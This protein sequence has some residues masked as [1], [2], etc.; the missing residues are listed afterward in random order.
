MTYPSGQYPQYPQ[1]PP[2]GPYTGPQQP[3]PPAP[4]IPPRRRR[5]WPWLVG[6]F[7]LLL[8]VG[9]GV[10]PSPTPTPRTALP[11][12][13]APPSA[14]SAV[15]AVPS[16]DTAPIPAVPAVRT[17]FGAGETAVTEGGMEIT[18]AP[19]TTQRFL[20]DTILCSMV[21]YR[22]GT[23]T[24]ETFNGLFDWE[25]QTPS[26]VIRIPTLGGDNTLSAGQLTA[27][28]TVRGNICFENPGEKGDYWIITTTSFWSGEKFRWKATI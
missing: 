27:G 18:A 5:K 22:N 20:G 23:G 17:E 7:V 8:F 4:P 9:I 1:A 13:T 15:P 16:V 11:V 19:F 10:S 25:M 24:T 2:P 6:G 21:A 12:S 14:I 26:G 3:W 28:G